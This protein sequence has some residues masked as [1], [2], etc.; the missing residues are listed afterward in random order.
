MPAK[1]TSRK[2]E[3]H[4]VTA[5]TKISKYLIWHHLQTEPGPRLRL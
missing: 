3:T 1:D 5:G 4:P 2:M